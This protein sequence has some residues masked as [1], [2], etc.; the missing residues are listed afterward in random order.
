VKQAIVII[1]N[2]SNSP[3][4]NNLLMSI[5]TDYPIIITN[6]NGWM[7][8]AIEKA[9][10]TTDFDELFFLNESMVVKDNS[11]WDIVFKDNEGRGITVGDNYLMFLGKYLRKYVEQTTFPVVT[12]KKED[13][14]LGEQGWNAQYRKADPTW[15]QIEGMTDTFD[16]FE[17]KHGRRNMI[18]E[19]KYF[20]KWKG[21]W[22]LEMV[23]KVDRGD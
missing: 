22:T 9:F 11:I 19:G 18:L 8:P 4:L 1:H 15:T 21:S 23:E 14:L 12:S 3:W 5:D 20:K 13:V 7:M 6:H 10:R 17:E 16:T 2:R